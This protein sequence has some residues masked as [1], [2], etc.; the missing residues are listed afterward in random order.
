[1]IG[2]KRIIVFVLLSLSLTLSSCVQQMQEHVSIHLGGIW[3]SVD[4]YDMASTFFVFD[5]G[6]LYE[7]KAYHPYYVYDNTIWGYDDGEPTPIPGKYK[8]SVVD[9]VLYYNDFLRIF[10]LNLSGMAIR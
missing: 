3:A 9:G 6:Y 1:M 2:M 10:R 8:Y 4:D 5:K 7:Y